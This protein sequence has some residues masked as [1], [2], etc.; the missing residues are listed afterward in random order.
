MTQ[1]LHCPEELAVQWGSNVIQKQNHSSMCYVLCIGNNSTWNFQRRLHRGGV[2]EAM[3][4]ERTSQHA[5][6]KKLQVSWYNQNIRCSLAEQTD[7]SQAVWGFFSVCFWGFTQA[8]KQRFAGSVS[9]Q[10][11]YSCDH[12]DSK[13]KP[14]QV[15]SQFRIFS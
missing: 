15:I 9:F 5:K 14:D 12:V 3:V 13:I 2:A 6:A 4:R 8:F 7:Q 10:K 1:I 11:Y